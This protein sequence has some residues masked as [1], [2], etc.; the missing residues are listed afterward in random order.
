MFQARF[1]HPGGY[2]SP[3]R[4]SL[5][6]DTLPR[7]THTFTPRWTC[8][9]EEING[10]C[11][12]LHFPIDPSDGS[13]NDICLILSPNADVKSWAAYVQF[14][15]NGHKMKF[16]GENID[17]DV[18]GPIEICFNQ[19]PPT[20]GEL[21]FYAQG[22][23]A[24]GN[25]GP[26]EPLGCVKVAPKGG[27]PIPSITSGAPATETIPGADA[28]D[29]ILDWV[30]PPGAE[31][32]DI[33][34]TPPPAGALET[35]LQV[36]ASGAIREWGTIQTARVPTAF[37]ANAPEFSDQIT[38]VNGVGYTAKVRAASGFGAERDE[39]DW[40][41]PFALHWLN[42]DE[43]L[44]EVPWPMRD[45]PGITATK[46]LLV[47]DSVEKILRVEIGEVPSQVPPVPPS[48]PPLPAD[49]LDPY[50]FY[51]L[52]FVAYLQEVSAGADGKI[53][54]VTHR[55]DELFTQD[56]VGGGL[57]II[58]QSVMFTPG[59]LSLSYRMWLRIDQAVF[60]GREYRVFLVMHDSN[61]EIQEILR[62]DPVLVLP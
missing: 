27:L 55:I 12:G 14:G 40:S 26:V 7:N 41:Q 13:L 51:D 10:P 21:C 17:P 31:R 32:F 36:E 44:G 48:A 39:G 3:W 49:S 60:A 35:F 58:D 11:P 4:N 34:L 53:L 23:D 16:A 19:F 45:S 6:G 9:E 1:G 61:G 15:V 54:Q 62:T 46:P 5:A 47:W 43:S 56:V 24:G 37:G 29:Y 42:Q 8:V 28:N 59:P 30:C 50:L 52:P 2:I 22:F 25:P 18:A 57:W 33:A 38:L 20:G